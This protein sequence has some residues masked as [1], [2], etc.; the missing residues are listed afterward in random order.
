MKYEILIINHFSIK[1][2][3]EIQVLKKT[4]KFFFLVFLQLIGKL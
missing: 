1:R 2:P 3:F 4:I